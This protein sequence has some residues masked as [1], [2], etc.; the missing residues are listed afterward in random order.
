MHIPTTPTAASIYPFLSFLKRE[1]KKK[2]FQFDF[3][4][5]LKIRKFFCEYNVI[6]QFSK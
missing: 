4:Y 1:R 3:V 5:P 6:I 2:R